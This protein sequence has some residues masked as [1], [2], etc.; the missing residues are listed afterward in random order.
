[1]PLL[2]LYGGI[3][4]VTTNCVEEACLVLNDNYP[5]IIK[6]IN[7]ILPNHIAQQPAKAVSIYLSFSQM[8]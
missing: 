5:V 4:M 2:F 7:I 6:R 8:A 1:M 3:I